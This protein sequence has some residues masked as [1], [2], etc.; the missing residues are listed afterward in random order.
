MDR[1]MVTQ[2]GLSTL[3]KWAQLD[4][5]PLE[6]EMKNRRRGGAGNPHDRLY[7]LIRQYVSRKKTARQVFTEISKVETERRRK[8]FR[9][10]F[11]NFLRLYGDRAWKL[12]PSPRLPYPG[13]QGVLRISAR[14]HLTLIEPRRRFHLVLWNNDEPP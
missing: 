11:K 13:R 4:D 3:M 8:S 14:S 7:A 12:R 2:L 1:A 6:R 9:N 10:G 5:K